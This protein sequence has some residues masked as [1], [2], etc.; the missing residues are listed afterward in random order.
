MNDP[1]YWMLALTQQILGFD[2]KSDIWR[3][4]I[5]NANEEEYEPIENFLFVNPEVEDSPP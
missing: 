4:V 1:H 2:R 3:E 5:S